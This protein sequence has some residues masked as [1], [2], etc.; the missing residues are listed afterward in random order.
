MMEHLRKSETGLFATRTLSGHLVRGGIAFGLLYFAITRQHVHPIVALAAGIG[1]LVAM[2]GCPA[3][4]TLGL[5]ET[6]QQK[7]Q[8]KPPQE[9]ARLS[10]EKSG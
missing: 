1:A 2:R 10:D 8:A 9:A 3:C 6:I 5:M 7:F 4:W